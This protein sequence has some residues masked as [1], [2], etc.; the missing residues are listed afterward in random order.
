MKLD[1]RCSKPAL[2]PLIF[3]SQSRVYQFKQP[4][5][6]RVSDKKTISST[7]TSTNSKECPHITSSAFRRNLSK[8][9]KIHLKIKMKQRRFKKEI[10]TRQLNSTK[11]L[12]CFTK[13]NLKVRKKCPTSTLLTFALIASQFAQIKQVQKGLYCC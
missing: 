12:Q 13:T 9:G 10:K 1:K 2:A 11:Q 5:Y 6:C 7:E 8:I 4:T 3:N